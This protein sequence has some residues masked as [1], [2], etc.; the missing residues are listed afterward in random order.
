M[1][2]LEI[3]GSPRFGPVRGDLVVLVMLYKQSKALMA[4]RV[5]AL[6]TALVGS[7]CIIAAD[8]VRR[9]LN[10]LFSLKPSF[11]LFVRASVLAF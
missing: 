3:P 10:Q 4:T 11:I 7:R 1:V 5:R 8:W 6:K 2:G 9:Q